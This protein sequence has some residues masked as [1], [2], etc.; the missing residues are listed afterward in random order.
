MFRLYWKYR[1]KNTKSKGRSAIALELLK[2][3]RQ[4]ANENPT[5]GAPRIHGELL[6]L[7]FTLS[8]RTVSRYLSKITSP[9]KRKKNTTWKVF[10]NNQRKGFAGMDFFVVPTLF[11]KTLYCFFIIDHDRRK[12]LHFNVT[13]HPTAQWVAGQ[14][15]EAFKDSH[16]LQGMI[17]DRDSIFSSLVRETLRGLGIA[18]RRT[19]FRSPWQ[20]GIAERW[21]GSCR[22]ELLDHVIILQEN[23]LRRLLEEYVEY[24]NKDR[25]HYHL[26]KDPPLVRPVLK[27]ESESDRVIALLRVGGLHH[28]YTWKKAA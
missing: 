14:L 5:W 10:L 26:D 25:T 9:S 17:F 8:E 28:R 12:V 23:H 24:Y 27:K 21:I 19:S 11:F 18:E 13:A 2:L 4:M 1:S 6:K 15:R 7:G 3:I 20:N 16:A 22:R